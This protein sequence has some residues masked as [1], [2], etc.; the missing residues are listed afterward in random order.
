W[1]CRRGLSIHEHKP[2]AACND[3]GEPR[4][5]ARPPVFFRSGYRESIA[6]V[7]HELTILDDQT[8]VAFVDLHT[9][10]VELLVATD[11]PVID[12]YR[13]QRILDGIRGRGAGLFDRQRNQHG[14]I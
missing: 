8:S 7:G 2:V 11:A 1:P 9:I 14:R 13:T 12:G 6:F 10:F 4:N 3:A 5:A